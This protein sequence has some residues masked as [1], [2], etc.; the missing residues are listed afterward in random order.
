MRKVRG[1]LFGLERPVPGEGE[2][3]LCVLCMFL[4]S[5]FMQPLHSIFCSFINE[6]DNW[7]SYSL[8]SVS[9]LVRAK[10]KLE[11]RVCSLPLCGVVCCPTSVVVPLL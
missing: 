5:V 10:L 7:N 9:L 8:L 11:P 6:E 1:V 4:P 2:H 3:M